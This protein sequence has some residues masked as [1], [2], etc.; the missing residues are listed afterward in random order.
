MQINSAK[1]L[2]VYKKA[3]TLAMRVFELSKSFSAEERSDI[4]RLTSDH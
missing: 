3:Y 4:R 2:K 1:D